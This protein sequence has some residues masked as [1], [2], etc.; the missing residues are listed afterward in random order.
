M[1]WPSA[2]DY[3]EAVQN[4]S[5]S[6][7]D[8][9]L[10]AG[11]IDTNRL[12][13]P[14][15]MSGAFACVYKV[16]CGD[17]PWA[18]RCFLNCRE[19][20]KE[21]YKAISNF[22]VFDDLECTVPFYYLEQGIKV[23]GHWYPILKMEWVEGLTL[24]KFI[25]ENYRNSRNVLDLLRQFDEMV[26]D[27]NRA[28][29]AHGDLQHGNIIVTGNGLRLVDYDALYVPE[30]NGRQSPEVGHPNFQHPD[31][32]AAQYDHN[33]DNF[34]AWLIHFSLLMI[35]VDPELYRLVEG[36][37]DSILFKRGD[38]K[39]PY[40][41][42]IFKILIE[43]PSTE[44]RQ[45]GLLLA[46]ML[47]VKP[48]AVPS[49]GAS[50]QDLAMLPDVSGVFIETD[51]GH[52]TFEIGQPVFLNSQA[53][54]V[55][56]V[57]PQSL[58]SVAAA[59]QDG[60][61]IIVRE[62]FPSAAAKPAG[63]KL[64]V[65]LALVQ[66]NAVNRVK[67]DFDKWHLRNHPRHWCRSRLKKATKQF[68]KGH[69]EEAVLVY[70]EL[71]D[72][73]E[74]LAGNKSFWKSVAR[75]GKVAARIVV[76]YVALVVMFLGL[77]HGDIA[78]SGF[79]AV[80]FSTCLFSSR[81]A[82]KL[83]IREFNPQL[84]LVHVQLSLG[85]CFVSREQWRVA[86]N[87][88]MMAVR[89]CKWGI[90]PDLRKQALL[91]YALCRNEGGERR[92]AA[93]FLLQKNEVVSNLPKLLDGGIGKL[94]FV[95]R[96]AAFELF[97][98]LGLHYIKRQLILS[99][100]PLLQAARRIHPAGPDSET[101]E[102]NRMKREL[103]LT[104]A[105]ISTVRLDWDAAQSNFNDLILLC[106]KTCSDRPRI[107]RNAELCASLASNLKG[108]VTGAT[109][110]IMRHRFSA[111]EILN[112]ISNP[113]SIVHKLVYYDR[114]RAVA[115]FLEIARKSREGNRPDQMREF[116]LA[117]LYMFRSNTTPNPLF[118][119]DWLDDLE[120]EQIHDCLKCVYFE[121]GLTTRAEVIV[122]L[123][124]LVGASLTKTVLIACRLLLESNMMD[125]VDF[126]FNR[127]AASNQLNPLVLTETAATEKKLS[128]IFVRLIL[129]VSTDEFGSDLSASIGEA[130]AGISANQVLKKIMEHRDASIESTT[131]IIY[132]AHGMPAFVS[133]QSMR[134]RGILRF[135]EV[136]LAKYLSSSEMSEQSLILYD[137]LEGYYSANIDRVL[138]RSIGRLISCQDKRDASWLRNMV[139]ASQLAHQ[140]RG[141]L[142][143]QHLESIKQ[144]V[145]A[146]TTSHCSQPE[147]LRRWQ[148]A[149]EAVDSYNRADFSVLDTICDTVIGELEK[150][151][152]RSARKDAM[153]DLVVSIAYL[154]VMNEE[155]RKAVGALK[156]MLRHMSPG[157]DTRKSRRFSED[158]E[159]RARLA[160][161]MILK[162]DM[163]LEAGGHV[164]GI[165][166][167]R[168]VLKELMRPDGVIHKLA[169]H[170]GIATVELFI[171]AG[172]IARGQAHESP[173]ARDFYLSAAFVYNS[174]AVPPSSRVVALNLADRLGEGAHGSR[175]K[176]ELALCRAELCLSE[177]AYE[178]ALAIHADNEGRTSANID[179]I[180]AEVEKMTLS[181]RKVNRTFFEDSMRTIWMFEFYRGK[182]YRSQTDRVLNHVG[183]VVVD[184]VKKSNDAEKLI[185]LLTDSC[186]HRGR[187]AAR[188]LGAI[189]SSL[190]TLIPSS[191]AS[192]GELEEKSVKAA[193]LVISVA[194][195]LKSVEEKVRR[196]ERPAGFVKKHD[197]SS[198]KTRGNLS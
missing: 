158:V 74:F 67:G 8:A 167:T 34:S 18:V 33:V 132:G 58:M 161:G 85:H 106:V 151:D 154:Y 46:S 129:R 196:L 165:F 189:A 135:I 177:G 123:T 134:Y 71:M 95:Q 27:L 93:R 182:K 126:L 113:D 38:L 162:L 28:G 99:A 105:Y 11:Q 43:H 22:V 147:K 83:Q 75:L 52:E 111:G 133:E 98:E 65:K 66:R 131:D 120:E 194:E 155:P 185:V 14:K 60:D 42:E 193:M 64:S 86:S 6:F 115:F 139:G 141:S 13:L 114:S 25:D 122:L 23:R 137:R 32:S 143:N 192:A 79:A 108:D 173:R 116:V 179:K 109:S 88:F 77:L 136:C 175:V 61:E 7:A 130:S 2:Q 183:R 127:M 80:V 62:A 90:D 50:A 117:L 89:N 12:G 172:N 124:A 118:S 195:S 91:L 166:E 3:N 140:Y 69:F 160:L 35:T 70:L 103:F 24:E 187:I 26:L 171:D 15:V 1:S 121:T 45:A 152:S 142:D 73:L 55:L 150:L 19:D 112:E 20:Q 4:P 53:D 96:V 128:E 68:D 49:L 51:T 110:L 36:G 30:L 190:R 82:S 178:E 81:L 153:A 76:A 87:Y 72:V 97:Y 44:L 100:V 146:A 59:R 107:L 104:L 16:N 168:A 159:T 17:T 31:R 125:M 157:E 181:K 40:R 92:E 176:F 188:I 163:E 41:S 21:R 138:E 184:H 180:L 149:V 148:E 198:G 78:L 84:S 48:D 94:E 39:D 186:S 10:R 144:S 101:E 54:Q 9:D 47:A 164:A 37:D 102:F 5:T 56:P 174:I 191:P 197:D 29:I 119:L 156:R 57:L 145:L 63:T 170:G 169:M